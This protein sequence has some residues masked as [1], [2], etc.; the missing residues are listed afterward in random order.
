MTIFS[1]DD[2]DPQLATLLDLVAEVGGRC[3][4]DA[5]HGKVFRNRRCRACYLANE[6]ARK[7]ARDRWARE[8]A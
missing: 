7:R 8:A 6:R 2:L 1:Y 5:R 4:N 3:F